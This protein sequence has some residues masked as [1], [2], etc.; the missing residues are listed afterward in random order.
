MQRTRIV[1]GG[2][3]LWAGLFV[4]SFFS[5]QGVEPTGDGFTR[6]M[7]RVSIFMSWHF[8]AFV[9]S[10]AVIVAGWPLEKKL[11]KWL[12]RLPVLIHVLAVIGVIGTAVFFYQKEKAEAMKAHELEMQKPPRTPTKTP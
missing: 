5:T 1:L 10:I 7:N 11:H 8:A 9:V 6:G 4:Y 12:S 3:V 2:L